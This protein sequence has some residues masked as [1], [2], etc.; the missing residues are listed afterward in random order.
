[1]ALMTALPGEMGVKGTGEVILPVPLTERIC[2]ARKGFRG[3]SCTGK[4][5]HVSVLVFQAFSWRRR[6]DVKEAAKIL[7]PCLL[8][9]MQP[10]PFEDLLHLEPGV[11]A[12]LGQLH[13]AQ[14]QGGFQ[15]QVLVTYV[16]E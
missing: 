4:S 8:H 6:E 9:G 15:K 16:L 11:Q 2:R 1:M 7:S 13:L 10:S 12:T 3:S 5:A 14:E